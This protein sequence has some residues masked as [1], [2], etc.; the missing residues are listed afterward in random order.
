M[1]EGGQDYNAVDVS[2]DQPFKVLHGFRRE[3][4]GAVIIKAGYLY[5]LGHRDYG[6]L[7][8][9]CRYSRLGQGEVKMS[10][11]TLASWSAH[12][13]SAHPGNPS[14]PTAF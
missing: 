5:F 10:V 14:G 8:K 13:L 7:L 3:C 2:H 1:F 12:A 11:K 9:T 4:H 6:G